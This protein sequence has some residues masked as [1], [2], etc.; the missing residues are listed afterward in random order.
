M[1]WW[2]GMFLM[3]VSYGVLVPEQPRSAIAAGIAGLALLLITR[4]W[5]V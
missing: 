4:G 3:G 5:D 2:I 1:S